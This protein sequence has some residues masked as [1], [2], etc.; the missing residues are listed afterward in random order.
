MLKG[1]EVETLPDKVPLPIFFTLHVKSV[2][3]HIE[4]VPK[5]KT[6]GVT[7]IVGGISCCILTKEVAVGILFA[8]SCM[9]L[10]V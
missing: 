6:V 8:P 3:C 10:K 9:V 7:E 4:V 2:N 1:S 5:S